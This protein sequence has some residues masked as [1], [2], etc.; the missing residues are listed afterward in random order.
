MS[1]Q[2]SGSLLLDS[3]AADQSTQLLMMWPCLRVHGSQYLFC[4]CPDPQAQARALPTP[5]ADLAIFSMLI[6]ALPFLFLN[7]D[8]HSAGV[9]PGLPAVLLQPLLGEAAAKEE[10]KCYQFGQSYTWFLDLGQDVTGVA[11]SGFSTKEHMQQAARKHKA[12][13]LQTLS[14]SSIKLHP[15]AL[16][17][18]DFGF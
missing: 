8:A 7:N 2:T 9:L 10:T 6:F 11:S 3:C 15:F 12:S 13:C 17:N 5:S 4:P 16:F 18:S 14:T 1:I